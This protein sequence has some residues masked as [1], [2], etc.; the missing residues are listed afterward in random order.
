MTRIRHG[1][2]A[3]CFDA[4][5]VAP[6][7]PPYRPCTRCSGPLYP[8]TARRAGSA[9]HGRTPLSSVTAGRPPIRRHELGPPDPERHGRPPLSRQWLTTPSALSGVPEGLCRADRGDGAAASGN[10]VQICHGLPEEDVC[11][12][13]LA[14]GWRCGRTLDAVWRLAVETG[15]IGD[16]DRLCPQGRGKN[17]R[18]ASHV[19]AEAMS[20]RCFRA[21]SMKRRAH[22]TP[23]PSCPRASGMRLWAMA[24]PSDRYRPGLSTRAGAADGARV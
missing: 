9:A 10:G 15:R 21:G 5:P 6:A 12:Q 13:R 23:G 8:V 16:A 7:G 11:R 18:F 14:V 1:V 24:V 19:E 20:L 2:R 3:N 17:R 4:Y 22:S